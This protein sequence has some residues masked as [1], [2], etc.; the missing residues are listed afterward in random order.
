MKALA[1]SAALAALALP[2]LAPSSAQAATGAVSVASVNLRAGPSSNYPVV[3][4]LPSRA[5]LTLFG[6]NAATTWCDVSWDGERGWVSATYVSVTYRGSATVVSPVIAPAVGV[7]VVGFSHAYWNAHYVGRPWYGHWGRHHHHV[8][9][10]HPHRV[11]AAGGCARGRCGGVVAGP[12]RVAAGGCGPRGCAGGVIRRPHAG[13]RAGHGFRS[14]HA[15]F[16]RR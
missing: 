14:A 16:R 11:K 2:S 15:G 1:F 6:C 13:V 3:A 7:T 8:R 4:L 5:P 10:H 12:R 9:P